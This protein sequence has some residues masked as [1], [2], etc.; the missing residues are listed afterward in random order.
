MTQ[1]ERDLVVAA[2]VLDL[3]VVIQHQDDRYGDRGQLV[4]QDGEHRLGHVLGR[5]ERGQD[6]ITVDLRTS[7]LQGAHD[8]P[9]QV[10]GV[11][12]AS[13]QRNPGE[14]PTLARASTPLRHQSRLT[15]PRRRGHEH[16]PGVGIRQVASQLSPLYPYLSRPGRMELGLHRPG[17]ARARLRQGQNSARITVGPL[18]IPR[19]CVTHR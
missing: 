7:S 8:M 9:P 14:P 10:V 11:I 1:Q 6:D 2:A 16:Q 13:I 3:V 15:E 18:P 4:E 12:V 5:P 17:Q 19:G